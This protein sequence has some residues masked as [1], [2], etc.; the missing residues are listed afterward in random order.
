M[1]L[2]EEGCSIYYITNKDGIN[3]KIDIS[4][5]YKDRQFVLGCRLN[6]NG[7]MPNQPLTNK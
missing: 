2:V 1:H 4:Q 3:W 7:D 5:K 6:V